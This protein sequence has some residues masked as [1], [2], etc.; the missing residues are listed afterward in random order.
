MVRFPREVEKVDTKEDNNEAGEERDCICGIRC[1]EALEKDQRCND[2]C[3]SKSNIIQGV[4]TAK[5]DDEVSNN[6][7]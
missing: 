4:D 2:S 1:V 5:N 6:G 7:E 3:G